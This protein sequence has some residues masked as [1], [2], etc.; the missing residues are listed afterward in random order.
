MTLPV[1]DLPRKLA[2]LLLVST[3][4]SLPAASSIC[5]AQVSYAS[6]PR[7]TADAVHYVLSVDGLNL[8]ITKAPL[9]ISASNIAI[10][11]DQTP[12]PIT[13]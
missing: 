2:N 1:R 4:A 10:A 11:H 3:I 9:Y 8:Q 7:A 13:G 6:L 5:V 12:P